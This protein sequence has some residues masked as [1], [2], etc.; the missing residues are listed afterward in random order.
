MMI[1]IINENPSD[2]VGYMISFLR[3]EESSAKVNEF[4]NALSRTIS[5]RKAVT[6]NLKQESVISGLSKKTIYKE[7]DFLKE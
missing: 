4:K 2:L 6:E 3:E 7:E 5:K 1:K